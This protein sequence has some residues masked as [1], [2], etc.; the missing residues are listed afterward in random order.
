MITLDGPLDDLSLSPPGDRDW[1][2]IQLDEIAANETVLTATTV[3]GLDTYMN[4]Y[5]PD[6]PDNFIAENDDSVDSNAS[7]THVV[8]DPGMYW[9][10]VHGY[11][12]SDTGPY[13]LVTEVSLAQTD[14][15]EPDNMMDDAGELLSDGSTQAHSFSPSGD[16]DWYYV[17][18]TDPIHDDGVVLSAETT[19]DIDTYLEVYDQ[20]ENLIA[21]DDDSGNEHN[22]LIRAHIVDSGRYYVMARPYDS[23][24]VGDYRISAWI[25]TVE[26]DG[27]EPNNDQA[28][29]AAIGVNDAAQEHNF[30]PNSD[31]DWL[32]FKLEAGAAIDV[33]TMGE[34]DT[35]LEL[36][37][38]RG[39]SLN[40]DDDSGYEI[41]A[42]IRTTLGA[43]TYYLKVTQTGGTS[44]AG[45][46]YK[47]T[48]R[49]Y[50]Q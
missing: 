25:D 6:D 13:S 48:V 47:I 12:D 16:R 41:N 24:V 35:Y 29:A 26:L 50:S 2:A 8:S 44:G 21:E 38:D 22:A 23:Q 3:G 49:T 42:R 15:F 36:Y 20:Q 19:S 45:N 28:S 40:E 1:F 31:E 46:P 4:L 32:V 34:T 11:S 10:E 39:N 17:D 27:Y 37:D 9:I 33:E 5:G 7:I 18:L 43:G 14:E 30:V